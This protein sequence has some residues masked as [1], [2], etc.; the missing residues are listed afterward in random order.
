M[1]AGE[2][3]VPPRPSIYDVAKLAGVSH[4]TVSR[5]VNG[6]KTSEATRSK[7]LEAIETT[8]YRP[9]S[10]ARALASR[11]AMRIGVIVHAAAQYGPASTLVAIERAAREAGYGVVAYSSPSRSVADLE[12]GI[13]Y[14]EEQ[15]VDAVCVIGPGSSSTL[16]LESMAATMP[17]VVVG[18]EE[19]GRGVMGV[20]VDQEQGA[21][22]AMRH[23]MDLGHRSILHLAGPL[24]TA[25]A[26]GRERAW[27]AALAGQSGEPEVL[28]GDWTAD[29]GFG[30][31]A[32][33]PID[34]RFTAVFAGNDQMALG[35][36]HG[37]WSRG[38][39]VP[40][41]VSVVGFDDVPDAA[42][43]LPP[44]T[45][46]RQDFRAL[47]SSVLGTVMD[48]IR[49]ETV[50]AVTLIPAELV[51]RKSTAAPRAV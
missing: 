51:V 39:R 50:P 10:V 12:R 9:S 43:F 30:V 2:R 19:I 29:F 18:S 32:R 44:L 21:G 22:R 5:V 24:E 45:T 25:D 11:R 40:D 42:H 3:R 49:G 20:S 7:V 8:G 33:H 14:L 17:V 48:A 36:I 23:L 47:G 6:G 28:L 37:L 35:L 31:G 13:V 46:V 38:I 41:D 4:M 15:S 34:G 26:Q 27:R 1:S 16:A